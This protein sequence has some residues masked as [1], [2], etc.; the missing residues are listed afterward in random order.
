MRRSAST[1]R[2]GRNARAAR[3]ASRRSGRGTNTRAASSPTISQSSR[4]DA[5]R[6]MT[7]S[8]YFATLRTA[9]AYSARS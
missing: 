4:S 1:I 6:G 9:K 5:F 2:S 8:E 7:G 3:T